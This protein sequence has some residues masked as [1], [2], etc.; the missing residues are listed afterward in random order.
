MAQ[1]KPAAAP[2][3]AAPKETS[4][5]VVDKDRARTVTCK[6]DLR[7]VTDSLGVFC[8]KAGVPRTLNAKL[9]YA[10]QGAAAKQE[11]DIEIK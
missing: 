1:E 6:A 4:T 2:D 9:V 11:V 7:V 8:L 10:A 5:P 3:A